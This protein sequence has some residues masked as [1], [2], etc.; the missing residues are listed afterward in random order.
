MLVGPPGAGKTTVGRRLADRLGVEFLDTD[1]AVEARAG[2]P[3]P[4]IFVT[5]GEPAF[6][7][8][9]REAVAAALAEHGGVLSLGGGAVLDPSTREL[10]G[11][12]RVVFLDVDLSAAAHRV[13]LDTP[14]PLLIGNPRATLRK[15]L[16]DRRPHYLEVATAVVATSALGP[17]EVVDAVLDVVRGG[18]EGDAG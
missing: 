8:L 15:Q 14:R 6:R 10:L 7:R 16:A 11:A 9:E 1:S 18:A 5:D 2:K 13:G 12:H 3:V 17:G 4:E